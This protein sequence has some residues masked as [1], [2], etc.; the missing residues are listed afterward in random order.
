MEY[1]S[2]IKKSE[3]LPFATTWVDLESI[4]LNESQ[5]EKDKC[6]MISL[7][8]NLRNK[9][10][11]KRQTKTNSFFFLKIYLF[12]ID[13]ERERERQRHR[14]EKQAP[15]QEPDMGLDPR[16]PGSRPGPK[17]GVK[18]LRHPG[19]PKVLFVN[20]FFLKEYNTKYLALKNAQ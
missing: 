14:R 8:W 7:M 5:S 20:C 13:I 17:A 9:T 10:N 4:I 19:I 16:T 18:P 1:Y 3:M 12:M 15:C 6:H 2:A 11:K